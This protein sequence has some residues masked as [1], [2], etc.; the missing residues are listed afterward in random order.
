MHLHGGSHLHTLCLH[1]ARAATQPY[2]AAAYPAADPPTPI[3][4]AGDQL[5]PHVIPLMQVIST[6]LEDPS[7]HVRAAALRACDALLDLLGNDAEVA[8]FHRLLPA[9]LKVC[10]AALRVAHVCWLGLT[11]GGAPPHMAAAGLACRARAARLC[12]PCIRLQYGI[13][14]EAPGI[15]VPAP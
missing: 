11:W 9:L 3:W 8:A 5:Q 2:T 12:C 4:P 13:W 6:G 7:Q 14:S 10:A 1:M 15:P